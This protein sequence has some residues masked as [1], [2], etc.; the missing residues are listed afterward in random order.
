MDGWS[1]DS[2]DDEKNDALLVRQETLQGVVRIRDRFA[3][4]RVRRPLQKA[5]RR[6]PKRQ[7]HAFQK[8]AI[9]KTRPKPSKLVP[10]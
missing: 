5:A 6:K 1:N 2:N 3:N 4:L 10:E 7:K 9:P 8:R